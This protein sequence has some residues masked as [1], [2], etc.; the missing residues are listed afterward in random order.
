MRAHRCGLALGCALATLF[1]CSSEPPP[2]PEPFRPDQIC[3][4]PQCPDTGDTQ[5]RVGFAQAPINATPENSA[6]DP[7]G[8]LKDWQDLNCDDH[9]QLGET[10][11]PRPSGVWIFNGPR[12]PM[13]GIRTEGGD[14]LEARTIVVK[15]HGLVLALSQVDLGGYFR[16]RMD[17]VRDLLRANG[18]HVDLVVI[19]STHN[20]EAPDT[21]GI[22]GRDDANPGVDL[23]WED[24]VDAQIASTI[25][26]A[27][28]ALE[29]AT[30]TIGQARVED[31]GSDMSHYVG[32]SRDP[33]VIDNMLTLFL[34]KRPADGAP[35][36]ALVNW[37][38]HPDDTHFANH[39]LSAGYPHFLR[40]GL[41]QGFTRLGTTY[42]PLAP[43]VL[44][45]QGPL[46]G[47]IGP[48]FQVHAIDD[49][50]NAV[51][52]CTQPQHPPARGCPDP[53]R[54]G[55]FI[56][57]TPDDC[58]IFEQAIGHGAATF[59]HKA[60]A[61]GATTIADVPISWRS[62]RFKAHVDN[63]GFQVAL[64]AGLINTKEIFDFD[65]TKPIDMDNRPNVLT[66]V[67]YVR[68]G[69]ASF[70]TAPG[71]LHPELFVGGYDGSRAGTYPIIKPDNPNPPDLS[72]APKPP[73]V[74]NLMEGE[75]RFTLGCTSDYLGYIVAE[76]N[77][78]LVDPSMGT[79]WLDEP[80][81]DHYEETRSISR[82]AETEIVGTQKKLLSYGTAA[83]PT[84][85]PGR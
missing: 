8:D 35:L 26:Q 29:P 74:C 31:A 19:G 2:Q 20:H 39:L 83:A 27:L 30:L 34:F 16:E 69:P 70:M 36:A 76:F 24:F 45:M 50:G 28:A 17:H 33:V 21:I 71:E 56:Q 40:D 3:P 79:P 10:Q 54:P 44:F 22:F 72:R 77:F 15:T 41:E 4:S 52:K 58:F 48:G 13:L 78:E 63:V 59:A 82:F 23:R 47:Q 51:H 25:H 14:G 81:G 7:N 57:V 67:H 68:L 62:K 37:A 1:A 9:W 84:A 53:A 66:E 38:A 61:Q 65:R 64:L 60:L 43:H 55:Q 42:P 5:L 49:Q 6:F 18:D 73:Y 12:R 46:G 75:Y 85:C 80:P 32:D 11:N